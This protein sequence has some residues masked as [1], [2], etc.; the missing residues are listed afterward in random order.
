MGPPTYGRLLDQ[1]KRME[2]GMD[3]SALEL[4]FTALPSRYP[5]SS[6][7]SRFM[8]CLLSRTFDPFRTD[9]VIIII[10]IFEITKD[11]RWLVRDI[12]G[13]CGV[14]VEEM[15]LMLR[16]MVGP[17]PSQFPYR[18]A[19]WTSSR[20]LLS[21]TRKATILRMACIDLALEKSEEEKLRSAVHLSH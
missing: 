8:S 12:P 17:G 21:K 1:A 14:M 13:R 20:K 10:V 7:Y 16:S 5:T 19:I 11:G 2:R 18:S 9:I 3:R 15:M 6:L 4:S